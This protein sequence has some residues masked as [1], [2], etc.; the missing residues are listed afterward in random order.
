MPAVNRVTKR[1]SETASDPE[2]IVH[3]HLPHFAL[4][5]DRHSNF[6]LALQCRCDDVW[7]SSNFST[8]LPLSEGGFESSWGHAETALS[9]GDLPLRAR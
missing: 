1:C 3:V 9:T 7:T 2:R 6:I 4:A 5:V 8:T